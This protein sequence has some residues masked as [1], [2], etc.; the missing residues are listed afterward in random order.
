MAI[1]SYST[2]SVGGFD[3]NATLSEADLADQKA[4]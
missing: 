2:T 1:V 3:V 4:S